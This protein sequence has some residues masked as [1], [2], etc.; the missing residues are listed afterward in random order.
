MQKLPFIFVI[1][2]ILFL[3]IYRLQK[4][5]D[6]IQQNILLFKSVCRHVDVISTILEYLS[7]YI[8]SPKTKGMFL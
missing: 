4:L 5:I 1:F 3:Y 6:V 8:I 7:N 2:N